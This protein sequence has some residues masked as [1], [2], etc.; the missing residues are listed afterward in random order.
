MEISGENVHI[1]YCEV[2][3]GPEKQAVK[4]CMLKGNYLDILMHRNAERISLESVEFFR[5]LFFCFCFLFF[6]EV[7]QLYC[8]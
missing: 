7:L 1:V 8:K 3:Q 5:A 4:V 6:G 2:F